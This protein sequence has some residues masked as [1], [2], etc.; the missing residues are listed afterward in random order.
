MKKLFLFFAAIF[1]ISNLFSNVDLTCSDNIDLP[2]ISSC[3]DTLYAHPVVVFI[4]KV[5]QSIT[6]V[7]AI[8]TATEVGTAMALA[9][10]ARV[11]SINPVSDGEVVLEPKEIQGP[12]DMPEKVSE[13]GTLNCKL[14]YLSDTI[15]EH[16]RQLGIH[17]ECQMWYCDARGRFY[18]AKSGYRCSIVYN[19][20]PAKQFGHSTKAAINFKFS[21][22][23]DN[24]K[25]F[26]TALDTAYL[27]LQ[28]A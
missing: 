19:T 2:P 5:G 18:G 7:G 12:L 13:V 10:A 26:A 23:V 6:A 14:L 17:K 9:T 15:I 20:L 4:S 22:L 24:T 3:D 1:S 11:L 21:W 25:V 27:N 8:P 28:N 16:L